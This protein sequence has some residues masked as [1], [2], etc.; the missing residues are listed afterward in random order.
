MTMNK[1]QGLTVQ[2]AAPVRIATVQD[3]SKLSP[4]HHHE[5]KKV[6]TREQANATDDAF[7]TV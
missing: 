3:D 2:D 6:Q 1:R 7:G 4:R 5:T